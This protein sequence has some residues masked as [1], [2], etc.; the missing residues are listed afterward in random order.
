VSNSAALPASAAPYRKIGPFD[1]TTLPS[2]LRAEHRLKE[3]VWGKLE[4][5]EG[6]VDFVW[7]DGRT[8]NRHRLATGNIQW[9]TPTTPHHLEV[10]GPFR[11]TIEFWK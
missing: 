1:A 5:L 9:V 6:S 4:L 10:S 2:G 7:D 3:D 11:L 8:A